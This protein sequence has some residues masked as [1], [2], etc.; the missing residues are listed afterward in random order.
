MKTLTV[1]FEKSKPEQLMYL[2]DSS[3]K[4]NRSKGI[5]LPYQNSDTNDYSRQKYREIQMK[6]GGQESD[7]DPTLFN[8]DAQ[9]K[10][11]ILNM[12]EQSVHRNTRFFKDFLKDQLKYEMKKNS[13][14][15]SK[16]LSS[17]GVGGGGERKNRKSNDPN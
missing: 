15:F 6:I 3:Q 1:K 2:S 13:S 11:N 4:P 9:I 7:K 5:N 14:G 12:D 8:Q 10:Q 16:M 17:S